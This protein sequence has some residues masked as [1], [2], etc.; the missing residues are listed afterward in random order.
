MITLKAPEGGHIGENGDEPEGVATRPL[1]ETRI[2][3]KPRACY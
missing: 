1:A 3:V 2:Y